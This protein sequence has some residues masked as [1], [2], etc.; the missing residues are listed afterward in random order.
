[1]IKT[2]IF[3]YVGFKYFY[4]YFT[5]THHFNQLKAAHGNQQSITF[6]LE[7]LLLGLF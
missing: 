5:E 6:F 7:S 2:L 4:I 1:M 3:T